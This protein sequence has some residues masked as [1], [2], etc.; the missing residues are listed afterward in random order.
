MTIQDGPAS[1]ERKILVTAICLHCNQSFPTVAEAHTHDATCPEHPAVQQVAEAEA[2]VREVTRLLAECCREK[3][4]LGEQ[5]AVAKRLVRSLVADIQDGSM[6]D[7]DDLV[8]LLAVLGIITEERYNP[9]FHDDLLAPE[10]EIN[11]GD[12]VY[13]IAEAWGV[14]P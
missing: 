5:L 14:E 13:L 7:T 3:A 4:D 11:L 8:E 1:I 6:Y 2:H 10:V 9:A 12:P